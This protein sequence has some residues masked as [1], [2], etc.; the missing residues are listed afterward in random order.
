VRESELEK[1]PYMAVLGGREVEESAVNLRVHG[2]KEQR[3]LST[4]DFLALLAEKRDTK[5]L[6]Y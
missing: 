2:V 1:I 4:G 6:E 5:S 3:T